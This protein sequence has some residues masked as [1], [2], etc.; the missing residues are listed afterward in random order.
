M[1]LKNKI[2]TIVMLVLSIILLSGCELLNGNNT[3]TNTDEEYK[4]I[5]KAEGNGYIVCEYDSNARIKKGTELNLQAVANTDATFVAW[6]DE[7]NN[8]ISTDATLNITM[9]KK[10][11][12]IAKFKNQ[13]QVIIDE[14]PHTKLSEI[15]ENKEAFIKAT[16]LITFKNGFMIKDASGYAIVY[17]GYDTDYACGDIIEFK[18]TPTMYKNKL[19]FTSLNDCVRV[20]YELLSYPVS[21][22]DE[23]DISTLLIDP[24][25]GTHV[26]F[27]GKVVK[28]GDYYDIQIGNN[29]NYLYPYNYDKQL[30]PLEN[31]LNKECV[32][33]GYL[34]GNATNN[35]IYIILEDVDDNT[36]I[37]EEDGVIY[38]Y[39][40][41]S[42]TNPQI[43]INNN[44]TYN[45]TAVD[46]HFEYKPSG[47]VETVIFQSGGL[48]TETLDFDEDSYTFVLGNR[49]YNGLYD[50]YFTDK[51]NA[52][53]EVTKITTLELNDMHG[54][55][56][57]Q[58]GVNGLSSASYLI[59]LIRN[60]DDKD[61]V[62]LAANGDMFQGTALSNLT[63]GRSVVEIMN[64]MEFDF[65]GIGNHEFDWGL[66]EIFKYFDGNKNNGEA[67]FP[68][69]NS[70][71]Y[72]KSTNSVVV[73]DGYNVLESL[74]L[75]KDGLKIG[76]VSCI[77][78]L[79]SSILAT[80]TE[81]Y[82]FESIVSTA[83]PLCKALKDNGADIILVNLHDGSGTGVSD[84]TTNT[85]LA[86]IQ[87]KGKNLIDI[88]INGHTHYNQFG[89]IERN[90][91][92]LPVTQA[93]CNCEY[94]GE[95]C[96]YYDH[97]LGE[98]VYSRVATYNLQS[99]VGNK[100]DEN[101]EAIVNEKYNDVK[102]QLEETY[103]RAG[104]TVRQK[105]QLFDWA[106][107]VMLKSVG[108]DVAVSNTGGIRS[109]GRIYA[110]ENITLSNMF[111]I[112]PFDNEIILC[113]VQGSVL[114]TYLKTT[115]NYY[116]LKN[117]ADVNSLSNSYIYKV[118]VIDYVYYGNYFMSNSNP[119]NTHVIYREALIEDLKL[120]NTFNVSSD[121]SAVIGLLY[122]NN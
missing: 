46:D 42:W 104:E 26:T 55:I 20:G 63:R 94:L 89:Y 52:N 103:C 45:M 14:D 118:A 18:S 54:Y 62:I 61:N 38:A 88:V 28:V 9:N 68:L 49:R 81:D 113:E 91:A 33:T 13:T 107:Q 78:M 122:P 72:F 58:N 116:G 31:M 7:A 96:V 47:N 27:T 51:V 77:G 4:I 100:Y 39:F 57:R 117:N 30:F 67:N 80:R 109:T 22:M 32:F 74:M 79:K 93:A 121:K 90:G 76:V 12:L 99:V 115:S 11:V 23:Y 106:A 114:K 97:V 71:V 16:I 69:V 86:S 95:L 50:G 8:E 10:W 108:A 112:I 82:N 15:E 24:Q 35:N 87:Y 34:W 65:M 3:N 64:A 17:L 120:R 5:Y 6:Y 83:T 75:E 111:E 105:N 84:Y 2:I 66:E 85:S 19:Q 102:T 37:I 92:D 98:V 73:Y 48:K 40:D 70:N 119:I 25:Y 60:E 43:I 110:G 29:S 44:K 59:N 41:S 56:E 101:I 53:N 36:Q 1:K 21:E